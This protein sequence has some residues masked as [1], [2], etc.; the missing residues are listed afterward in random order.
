MKK[1]NQF[2]NE[3]IDNANAK[4][5]FINMIGYIVAR[6]NKEVSDYLGSE[7]NP[8]DIEFDYDLN[9]DGSGNFFATMHSERLSSF[10]DMSSAEEYL[11]VLEL[12]REGYE[13]YI[14]ILHDLK[15]IGATIID[16]L[17][18]DETKGANKMSLR[19]T[20]ESDSLVNNKKLENLIK[21]SNI[22]T[23]YKL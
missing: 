20:V 14:N 17:D 5:L 6:L 22:I 2:I 12:T 19:L 8:N 23:R 9:E 15:S 13:K 7:I 18:K 3:N 21:S 11:E 4:T 1:Y 10:P 16:M